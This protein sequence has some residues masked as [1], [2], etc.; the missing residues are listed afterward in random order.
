MSDWKTRDPL[1]LEAA[2]QRFKAQLPGWWF[3]VCE[4]QVSCDASCAPT[5]ESPHI[6][7]IAVNPAFDSGFHAD[8]AQPSS[9][10]EA[11]D[12]VRQQALAAIAKATTQ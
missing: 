2:I 3:M 1:H 5:V 10:A 9:L 7:L 8:L 11:L 6:D 4:C 12:N